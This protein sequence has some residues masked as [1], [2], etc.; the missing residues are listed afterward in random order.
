ME[1]VPLDGCED[2]DRN[3]EEDKGEEGTEE[4]TKIIIAEAHC[5]P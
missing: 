4:D 1:N 5:A 3:I 2:S